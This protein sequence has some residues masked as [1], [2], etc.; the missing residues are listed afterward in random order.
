MKVS[1]QRAQSIRFDDCINCFQ[2][3]AAGTTN[4]IS[5]FL[6][7]KKLISVSFRVFRG[8]EL[9][10]PLVGVTP[11]YRRLGIVTNSIEKY[12]DWS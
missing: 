4:H 12:R 3:P 10:F 2:E 5:L 9:V 6:F 8:S 11:A 7:Q 1:E